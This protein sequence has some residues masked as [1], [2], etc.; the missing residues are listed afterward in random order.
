VAAI[1][2]LSLVCGCG[3]P[4]SKSTARD[5]LPL[6]LDTM[7]IAVPTPGT[8]GGRFVIG[9]TGAPKT[10]NPL[11]ASGSTTSDVTNRIYASLTNFDYQT[12][13]DIPQLAKSWEMASDRVT[14]TY[15][16]RR[17]AAFSD[18]HPVTADDVLFSF[19]LVYDDS[20]HPPVAD[21]LKMNGRRFDVSAIDS[22]TVVVR[23]PA[24]NALVLPLVSAVRILPRHVLEP[25]FRAGR[26]ASRY[27][28]DT[29]PE[30]LVTSGPWRLKKYVPDER[31]VLAPNPW[32]FQVDARG[33]RLPY[34]DELVFLIV[35]D[36]DAADLKFRA[37]EIDALDNVKPENYAWYAEHQ[38]ANGYTL[39]D[40][41][42]SL[43]SNFFWFNLNRLRQ[44]RDGRRAGEPAVDPMRYAWFRLPEF[45]RAVSLAIN[46]DAMVASAYF[47]DAVKNWST[48]TA[49]NRTWH[50]PEVV[51]YD[52]DPE[53]A[54]RLLAGLGW[55]DRDGDGYVED[56]AG[57]AIAF[58]ME[59]NGDNKIRVAMANLVRD[60]LAKVGIKVTLMPIELNTLLSHAFED[61]RYECALLGI[62]PGVP[63]DPGMSQNT[64][65]SSGR[66]HYWHIQQESP[67]TR[68]EAR[69][70]ALMDEIVS[71]NDPAARHRAW[72]EIQN[73]VNDQ[74]WF[75]WLPTLVVKVPVSN[76]FG[77]VQP[78]VIP[79]RILW[80]I[81]TVYEK[82]P[83]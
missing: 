75:V 74:C 59:T 14:W 21:L 50:T 48:A 33:T 10:F 1:V 58:T 77:N 72:T 63:P 55:R 62:Q 65:R 18:G 2:A 73:T 53:R 32:W 17:G 36:Q 24:P 8:H 70:D 68:D 83:A 60:D 23:T 51:K 7:T 47:G 82:R 71:V 57:H 31:V 61:F 11:V 54:R 5:T 44:P 16:L 29:S 25:A 49:G 37:R 38:R 80:N 46:R 27:G 69:I 56:R 35:P 3:T 13:R 26:F 66:T 4:T 39:Y 64:W 19:E 22:Y 45:R 12:M 67:E 20:L 28:L 6:P 79:H 9:A 34:L 52:Y 78:S 40:L 30:S 15:H 81:E 42:P 41:G 76:R 43:N